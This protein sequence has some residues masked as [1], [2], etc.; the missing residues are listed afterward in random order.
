[1]KTKANW[2]PPCVDE[3]D[4]DYVNIYTK[5]DY[6]V[7]PYFVQLD[8]SRLN[9]YAYRYYLVFRRLPERNYE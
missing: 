1:M 6:S 9:A 8:I 4:T 3:F 7:R 5:F 2:K